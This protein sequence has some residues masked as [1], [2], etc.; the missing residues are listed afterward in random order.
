MLEVARLLA[1]FAMILLIVAGAAWIKLFRGTELQMLDGG[2]ASNSGNGESASR[3]LVLAAVLSAVAASLAVIG[4][5][6]P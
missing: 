3:L 2:A 1:A 4:W 6:S 5:I